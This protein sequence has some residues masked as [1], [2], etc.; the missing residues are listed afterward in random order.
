MTMKPCILGLDRQLGLHLLV[1]TVSGASGKEPACQC[2]RHKRRGFDPYVGK[3]PLEDE[4]ATHS[5]ILVRENPMDRGARQLQSV[6]SQ[7]SDPTEAT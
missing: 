3:I 7:E 5:Y 2:R 4:M 6:G 1:P